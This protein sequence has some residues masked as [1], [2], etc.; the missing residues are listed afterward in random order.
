MLKARPISV[1]VFGLVIAH[2]AGRLARGDGDGRVRQGRRQKAHDLF[3]GHRKVR[4][5]DEAELALG[6]QHALAHR[7]ALAGGMLV[8]QVEVG[9]LL[10][11][12]VHDLIGAVGAAVLHHDDLGAEGLRGQEGVDLPEGGGQALGFVV[13]R[14]DEGEQGF[15]CGWHG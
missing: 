14:D 12:P 1:A 9:D 3:D 11:Q 13:G 4:V 8:Q 15:G 10:F 5:A 6:G 7:P 2:R